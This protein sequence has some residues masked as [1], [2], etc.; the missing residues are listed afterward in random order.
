MTS[1]LFS[2]LLVSCATMND[3]LALDQHNNSYHHIKLSFPAPG[4]LELQMNRPKKRNAF[5]V[6]HYTEIGHF[7]THVAPALTQCR[8]ILLTG[9]G[10]IFSAG[11]DLAGISEG[12]IGNVSSAGR[13]P[14]ADPIIKKAAGVLRNGGVWQR[15]HLAIHKCRKPVVC[16]IQKGCYGAALE[17]VCFADIRMCTSDCVFQ[18]PEVDLG[19]A[20]D[21]GG[22][23]ML[24]KII[25][26]DSL[27]RELCLT[28]RTFGS[29]EAF[30]FGLVSRVCKDHQELSQ[31]ALQVATVI[32][33]KSPV[34]TQGVKTM[35]NYTRDHSVEDSMVFGLAW[36]ASMIQS[37]DT[38]IA[39]MAFMQKQVP[40]FPD[41]PVLDQEIPS[42]L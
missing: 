42:K 20:A 34:A 4:V 15:C 3:T 21:V 7:F 14:N 35:L 5:N 36:N 1:S 30:S 27:L 29:Q 26:N 8:C 32:A 17:M 6:R 10:P 9:A 18:A 39:G 2:L 11:I 23:Q 37:N 25:G 22:N 38:K 33:A 16:A 12:G 28:G 40:V 13:S 24:P 31:H 19:F 41:A